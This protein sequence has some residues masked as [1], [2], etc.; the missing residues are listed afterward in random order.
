MQHRAYGSLLILANFLLRA[1]GKQYELNIPE[2]LKGELC[3][4][5]PSTDNGDLASAIAVCSLL[6]ADYTPSAPTVLSG[7]I[8]EYGRTEHFNLLIQVSHYSDIAGF[9][10][11]GLQ[12]YVTWDDIREYFITNFVRTYT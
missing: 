2:P 6:D 11:Y 7:L 10:L 8:Q 5:D 1:Q 9:V 3:R 4:L 12:P